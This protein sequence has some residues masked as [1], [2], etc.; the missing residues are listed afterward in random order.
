MSDI[1]LDEH[2]QSY[3]AFERL[4]FF[5]VLHIALTLASVALAFIG[6]IALFGLLLWLGGTLVLLAGFALTGDWSRSSPIRDL[7]R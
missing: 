7:S 6:H 1:E 4:V 2:R 3:V 5:A